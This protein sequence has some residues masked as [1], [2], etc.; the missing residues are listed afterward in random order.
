MSLPAEQ[1]QPPKRSRIVVQLDRAKEMAHLPQKGSRGARILLIVLIVIASLL[2][3]LA[4]GFFFWWRH[5]KTGPAYSLAL[6]VDAAQRNDAAAVDEIVDTNKVIES[7]GPQVTEQAA[8]RLGTALTP[9]M[10]KQIEALV[11]KLLPRIRQSVHDEVIKNVKEIAAN[12]E[13]RSFLMIALA[14][15]YILDI[16]EEGDTAKAVATH[17]ERTI[18]LTMQRN[19]ERW[20]IVGVRDEVLAKRI[21]DNIAR[22]L[23]PVGAPLE[24]EVRKQ[25]QKNLP[26]GVT[27]VLGMGDDEKKDEKK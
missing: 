19:G 6:L 24:K 8:G 16:D 10:R 7:F 1:N 9:A 2:L 11:P 12:A 13:G 27:D 23:P 20:K 25:I 15:P 18:E 5:Y 14:I 3:G 26:G 21:V 22:D 17:K 4:I